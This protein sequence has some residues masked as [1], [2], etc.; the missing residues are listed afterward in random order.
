M[1]YLY[2]SNYLLKIICPVIPKEWQK[3][4]K[5]LFQLPFLLAH[6][7]YVSSERKSTTKIH[8]EGP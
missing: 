8:S 7:S 4:I 1:E 3:A 2:K 6:S 5:Q